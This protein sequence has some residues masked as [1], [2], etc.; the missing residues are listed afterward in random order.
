MDMS[1][2]VL[3]R[4]GGSIWSA[5]EVGREGVISGFLIV[6]VWF[7]ILLLS[8]HPLWSLSL[9]DLS[10]AFTGGIRDGLGVLFLNSKPTGKILY[11]GCSKFILLLCVFVI[12]CLF[13]GIMMFQTSS[14]VIYT[15]AFQHFE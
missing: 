5:L 13:F 12:T 3:G 11:F 8:G 9:G 15:V 14:S 10:M 2:F 1:V 7:L 6:M 4:M